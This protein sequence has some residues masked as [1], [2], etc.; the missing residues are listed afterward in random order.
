MRAALPTGLT[1]REIAARAARDLHEGMYVNL[2]IGLPETVPEF[3]DP[4]HEVIFQ[5]ENG[6]IGVG[7][8]PAPGAVDPDLINAGKKP[9]TLLPGGAFVHHN[10]AFVMIRGGH[11][12]VALLGAFE[13]SAQGDLANWQTDRLN[14]APAIGGAMDLAVGAGEVRV[15]MEHTTRE[16]QPR[17]VAACRYPLTARG[18]VKRIYTNLA[19][20]TVTAAGLYV[21][22]MIAGLSRDDLQA[23]TGAPFLE[24]S[25]FAP[26]TVTVEKN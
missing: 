7:P 26:L 6:V 1:R 12:D 4:K 15:L 3:I 19:V 16:L 24:E 22:E 21:D 5:S 8:A 14:S 18:V 10:D 9:V 23:I 17:I 25:P 2:G 13:V 11:I 20:L